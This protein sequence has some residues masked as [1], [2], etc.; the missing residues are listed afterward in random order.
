MRKITPTILALTLGMELTLALAAYHWFFELFSHY[1][2]YILSLEALFFFG[3]ITLKHWKSSTLIAFFIA[4]HL[5]LVAPYTST[6]HSTQ[7]ANFTLYSHNLYFENSPVSELKAALDQKQPDFVVL[8]EISPEWAPQLDP[9]LANYP[10]YYQTEPGPFG[11]ILLSKHPAT[12]TELEADSLIESRIQFEDQE[13]RIFSFHP[14]PPLGKEA[15]KRQTH[16]FQ[17][18]IKAIQ[19]DDTP[20][21]VAGD[22]NSTPFSPRFQKLL[23]ETELNDASLGFGLKK[24]W[25][26]S[27]WLYHI[28]ID[29]ILASP[30]IQTSD[31]QVLGALGSDHHAI[32]GEFILKINS[33]STK[34]P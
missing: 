20:T 33:S 22:F 8:L 19:K 2:L 26:S 24:T 16:D 21:L 7:S 4:L 1:L 31:F 18:L 5:T 34:T 27:S 12:F 3:L 15:A 30:D 13:L 17:V 23:H 25:H 29:H 10:Y 6:P 14:I 11:Q 28:P 32:Y 9:F